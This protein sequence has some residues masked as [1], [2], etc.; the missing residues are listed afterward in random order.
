MPSPPPKLELTL[1]MLSRTLCKGK[2]TWLGPRASRKWTRDQNANTRTA[3][4]PTRQEH[5][6]Q[7]ST[8]Y[9]PAASPRAHNCTCWNR[10]FSLHKPPVL[11]KRHP[12]AP[13]PS[14]P[15]VVQTPAQQPDQL[16]PP[17][18]GRPPPPQRPTTHDSQLYCWGWH[19]PAAP[20]KTWHVTTRDTEHRTCARARP[21]R[22]T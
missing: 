10:A 15:R 1:R 2:C 13:T 12:V 8:H 3:T 21:P 14:T 9:T 16:P 18:R 6:L 19:H 17:E 5:A 22:A 7:R 11:N 20:K 4:K